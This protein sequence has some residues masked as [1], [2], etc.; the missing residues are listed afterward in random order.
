MFLVP[1]FTT[2]SLRTSLDPEA[3]ST[4][5][6]SQTASPAHP[7]LPT[8]C[9]ELKK[10]IKSA[11]GRKSWRATIAECGAL[12]VEK[13]QGTWMSLTSETTTIRPSK[14]CRVFLNGPASS[15][16]PTPR[17]PEGKTMERS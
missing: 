12:K 5:L 9:R 13:A 4:S 14:E 2:T 7:Y 17:G 15:S 10:P 11:S 3:P 6:G 16:S 1:V 8:R